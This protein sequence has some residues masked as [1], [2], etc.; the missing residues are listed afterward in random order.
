MP[1]LTTLGIIAVS[2]FVFVLILVFL[3]VIAESKFKIE[4]YTNYNCG[5]MVAYKLGAVR[6]RNLD[7]F[8]LG[9]G[10]ITRKK[11]K[12][13][14]KERKGV[15]YPQIKFCYGL[16]RDIEVVRYG[17]LDDDLVH[18]HYNKKEDAENY[19]RNVVGHGAVKDSSKEIFAETN[20]GDLF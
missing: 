17:D 2:I 15:F 12:V 1:S 10:I 4:S 3:T 18:V 19:C 13:R 8:G 20:H 5:W 11:L 16:W 6:V 9:L 7:V 14:V